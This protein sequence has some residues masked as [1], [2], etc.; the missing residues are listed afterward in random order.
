MWRGYG[1]D[2]VISDYAEELCEHFAA[3]DEDLKAK[4]LA[5]G[6]RVGGGGAGGEGEEEEEEEEEAG[7][8][9]GA[10]AATAVAAAEAVGPS[11]MV[12]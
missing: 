10:A 3:A 2:A 7:G 11:P 4:V 5:R 8:E 9:A 6:T 12:I 1:G